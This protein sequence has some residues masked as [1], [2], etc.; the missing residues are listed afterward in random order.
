M[1]AAAASGGEKNSA[2]MEGKKKGKAGV[3]VKKRPSSS[4]GGAAKK[5]SGGVGGSSSSKSAA[6]TK[7]TIEMAQPVQDSVLE[8]DGLKLFFLKHMKVDGKTQNFKERVQITN[9]KTKVYISVEIPFSKRYLKYLTKKYLKA[10]QLRDFLR[11]IASREN[12]YELR[13]FQMNQESNEEK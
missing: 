12:S 4:T 7:Y 8:S 11:V 5:K 13:Y 6:R 10:Q 1:K 3:A 9:D 2:T